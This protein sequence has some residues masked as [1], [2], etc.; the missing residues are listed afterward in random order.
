M[1][2]TIYDTLQTVLDEVVDPILPSN[3]WNFD[4][5]AHKIKYSKAFLYGLRGATKNNAES[6][7][8]GEHVTVGA[9]ANVAG[10][11]LDPILLFNG[12]DSSKASMQ[13]MVQEAGFE[14]ALVLMKRGKASMDDK[15]FSVLLDWFANCLNE[16]GYTGKHILLVDNHDSHERSQPIQVAMKHNIILITFPSHCTHLVQTL[17]LSF[18]GPLKQAWKKVCAKWVEEESTDLNPYISKPVFVTLFYRAWCIAAKPENAINGWKKMGLSV[19]RLTGLLRIDRYAIPDRALAASDKYDTTKTAAAKQSIR[20]CV[21]ADGQGNSVFKDFAFDLSQDGLK[22]MMNES[23]ELYAM[24]QVTKTYLLSQPGMAMKQPTVK[25]TKIGQ[26]TTR[27]LTDGANLEAAQAKDVRKA[28]TTK[29]KKTTALAQIGNELGVTVM[30]N[31]VDVVEEYNTRGTR[32]HYCPYCKMTLTRPCS[33]K[34]CKEIRNGKKSSAECDGSEAGES[35]GHS[36]AKNDDDDIFPSNPPVKS[37]LHVDVEQGKGPNKTIETFFCT[38]MSYEDDGAVFLTTQDG[39]TMNI[40]LDDYFWKR[41][42]LCVECKH[43]G[44][45][46]VDCDACGLSRASAPEI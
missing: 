3:I 13:K 37:L 42:Y 22:T 30:V 8:L 26:P 15:L 34:K 20:L 44:V 4:E 11:F 12:A 23:P 28:A 5:T 25:P 39:E 19:D 16:R 36:D 6:N 14:N 32:K 2:D 27:L 45:N 9:F 38:V 29:K 33:K 21:S 46:E 1:I 40:F 41:V 43:Y 24:Y 10:C 31:G 35:D 17:D 7:G 18:F